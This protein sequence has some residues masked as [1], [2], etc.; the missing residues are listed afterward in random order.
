MKRIFL[1]F[2]LAGF[3]AYSQ[4]VYQPHEVGT[5]AEPTGGTDI[6]NLFLSSNLRIPVKSSWKGLSGRV[7]IKAVI[8]TDGSPSDIAVVRGID[9]LCNAEAARVISL[10][11]AWKPAS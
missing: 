2:L 7:I 9:T 8:E 11:K 6:F 4:T 5:P 10:Y 1:F 3:S